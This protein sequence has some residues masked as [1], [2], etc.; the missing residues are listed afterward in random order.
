[1]NGKH[2]AE[3]WKSTQKKSFSIAILFAFDIPVCLVNL[4]LAKVQ[5]LEWL[6]YIDTVNQN[7][8]HF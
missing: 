1:M 5:G 3:S 2:D 7:L 8:D 6:P 4:R